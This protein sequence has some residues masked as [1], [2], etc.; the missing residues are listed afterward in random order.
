QRHTRRSWC[1]TQSYL[2]LVLPR[3]SQKFDVIYGK[4]VLCDRL[5]RLETIQTC[6]PKA[7][8]A[9]AGTRVPHEP[10]RVVWAAGGSFS[11]RMNQE[12]WHQCPDVTTPPR[13]RWSYGNQFSRCSNVKAGGSASPE[14]HVSTS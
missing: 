13:W 7:P 8:R 3:S 11:R 5:P 10:Q 12:C 4:F 14:T 1:Q 9:Q 6:L 2:V